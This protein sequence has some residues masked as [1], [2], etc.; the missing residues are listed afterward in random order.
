M[1]A[2]A[3]CDSMA[4][5][6]GNVSIRVTSPGLLRAS[7][8]AAIT[9]S[10]TVTAVL[11]VLLLLLATVAHSYKA[12]RR[13]GL[14]FLVYLLFG[15]LCGQGFLLS[16]ANTN[17]RNSGLDAYEATG[18]VIVSWSDC[19]SQSM[20]LILHLSFLAIP[21]ME[22][23]WRV[24][25]KIRKAE[26]HKLHLWDATARCISLAQSAVMLSLIFSHLLYSL[27][28]VNAWDGRSSCVDEAREDVVVERV[29]YSAEVMWLGMVLLPFPVLV[30]QV[31]ASSFASI[32]ASWPF[33]LLSV[34]ST[35]F[36]ATILYESF[37]VEANSPL[38][39]LGMRQ[40]GVQALTLVV[41]WAWL[42]PALRA[43]LKD[44][45]TREQLL[46]KQLGFQVRAC[47]HRHFGPRHPLICTA[48]LCAPR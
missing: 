3:P 21:L 9:L 2:A 34:L 23:V 1:T 28:D 31:T 40:A 4:S 44:S 24:W 15:C 16:H 25:R 12:V 22:K 33:L 27:Q 17:L 43:K 45:C 29:L 20:L 18:I 32:F 38:V 26:T 6:H 48:A 46:Q 30:S 11:V 39:K 13:V 37:Y 7:A 47:S 5:S 35:I 8:V 41:L 14:S 42:L 36:C 10:S 19:H